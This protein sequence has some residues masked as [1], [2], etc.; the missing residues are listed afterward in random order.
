MD[1]FDLTALDTLP[2]GLP[3]N[4]EAAHDLIHREI[5]LG[6]LFRDARTQIISDANAPRSARGELFSSD[7]AVIEPAMTASG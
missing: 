1:S 6:R 4:A 2:H 7:D 5:P 3:G